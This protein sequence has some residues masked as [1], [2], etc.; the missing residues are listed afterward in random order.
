[1]DASLKSGAEQA[2][3]TARVKLKPTQAM[4]DLYNDYAHDVIDR[5]TFM[6]RL[7]KYAVGGVTLAMLT[8]VLM[9]KYASALQVSENDSRI[10]VERVEY[11]SPDGAGKQGKK[12]GAYVVRPATRALKLPAL[13]IVHENRGLNPHI[14]DVARKA[15]LS[16]Y[17]AF[18]PDALYPLGGYPGTDD[19][20][21]TM[22][23]SRD[24]G[25]MLQDF[26]AAAKLLLTHPQSTGKVGVT[27]FCYG[28]GV[29]NQIAIR[30][31][32]IS[33]AVPYYGAAGAAED[34]GKVKAPIFVVLAE[35]DE[36]VNAGYPAWEAAL[37]AAG[38][39]VSVKTYPGTMHGFHNDTTPRFD[40]EQARLAWNDTL[41]FFSKHLS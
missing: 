40:S 19:E 4:L 37:K 27:G 24:G 11:D 34:A 21:R 15:A 33:A 36:R 5:R 6:D 32:E 8:E 35:N 2:G 38:K 1:M 7:S 25:E 9:P 20:G 22:Q 10:V 12:M 3:G 29:S 18:A 23:A 14:A 17:L 31:P 26:V 30:V 41:S 39:E 28:G 16:G 13:L